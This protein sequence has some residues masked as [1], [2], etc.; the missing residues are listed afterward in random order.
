MAATFWSSVFFLLLDMNIVVWKRNIA[1][2]NLAIKEFYES[3]NFLIRTKLAI[4]TFIL[5]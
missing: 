2:A 3:R 4:T 5:S 1:R